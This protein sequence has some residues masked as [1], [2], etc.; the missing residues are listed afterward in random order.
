LLTT[1]VNVPCVRNIVFF[2]YVQSPILFHQM[3][4]R[5]TRIDEASGKL[6]FRI[7][8]YTGATALFG[9]DF[10]TPPPTPPKDDDEGGD[11]LPR[12][13]PPP[14]IK[15]K[16]VN[17][18]VKDAGEFNLL[19]VDGR[20]V[21]VTARQYQERLV[22]ELTTL[23]PSLATFREAWLDAQRRKELMQ[24][25]QGQ[26]LLPEKLREATD[27][28]A[29]DLFDVIAAVAYGIEPLTRAERVARFGEPGPAWLA[30]LPEPTGRVIRAVARQFERAG[31]E[32]LETGEL[33]NVDEVRAARGIAALREGG[34]PSELMKKTKEEIF[35]A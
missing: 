28:D 2:R 34:E 33:W 20:Q 10:V 9:S 29:F 31:T 3:V 25:L 1:G 13:E 5:G 16:G 11:G 6:M 23:L 32:A 17:I 12:P 27:M 26:G 21:R 8:D 14:A 22:Q 7:F 4:G 19:D 15:V 30:R 35:A 24:Q 18:A